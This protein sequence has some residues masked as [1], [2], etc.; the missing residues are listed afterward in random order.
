MLGFFMC[1]YNQA[2]GLYGIKGSRI[3]SIISEKSSLASLFLEETLSLSV[4]HR[5]CC[6]LESILFFSVSGLISQWV[7]FPNRKTKISLRF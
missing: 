7:T 6:I 3:I 4:V 5:F 1:L 2:P